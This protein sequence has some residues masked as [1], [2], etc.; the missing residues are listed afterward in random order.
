MILNRI[1]RFACLLIVCA[2]FNWTAAAAAEG[3]TPLAL[4]FEEMLDGEWAAALR[5]ANRAGPVARDIIEWHRLRAGRGSFDEVLDFLERRPDWPG[6]PH[7]RRRSE[8]A[9]P[10]GRRA[11]DV[12]A[13]FTPSAPR[14]G[15]GMVRLAA[16]HTELGEDDAAAATAIQAWRDFSMSKAQE[17]WL[18]KH[19]GERLRPHHE[20][21]LDMLIWTGR[22][23]AAEE[24]LPRVSKGWQALARARIAL[25]NTAPGVDTLIEKVP[26]ALANDPGLA[27]ERFLWRDRKDRDASAIELAISRP[28]TVE[29]L[30]RPAVWANKRR[31]FARAMMRQG[32]PATAYKLAAQHGLSEGSD[33]A[34]L[35]W[36][37]G[38]LS[39]RYLDNPE[40]A[41]THFLA[42][43]S[44]VVTPISLGRAGYWEGRALEDLGRE[45]EALAAYQRGGR[46]QTSFYGQLAAEKAGLKMDP[47]L[48]GQGSVPDW[49]DADFV[50]SSVFEAAVLLHKAGFRDLTER[51]LTHLT[52]SLDQ[53]QATQLANYAFSINEPHF[54]LMIAKRAAS[55]GIVLPEAYFPVVDLGLD[56]LPVPRELAL[57]I[58]R[59]ES[60]F[61]P[62]VRSHAGAVGLMQVMPATAQEVAGWLDITY[63][64]S[65][66]LNDPVYNAQ[67]GVTYL[68]E[69]TSILGENHM[70][71][72]A[73]YNAGPG[74]PI[75]WID[76]FG[77]PRTADID[78]VD[79][80][81]HIPFRE[82]RNYVMRVMES[83]PV[84]RARL[85]GEPQPLRLSKELTSG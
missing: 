48:A 73:G 71:V 41:L 2:Q 33:F 20:A 58:A 34:D 36:L 3:P 16:A 7:L 57:S 52:E 28:G 55:A 29:A 5:A 77:D 65:R 24:M 64:R 47:A 49:G 85:S 44:A 51:F 4:G 72:A 45:T 61:D 53:T 76:Q 35:E 10:L 74:R 13:F 79:W 56:A 9:V 66:L 26:A 46:Y 22:L 84:Y 83:L 31:A 63:S 68:A 23:G 67:L 8:G 38:Y 30:G 27:Y 1:L 59:R 25:R 50:N 12:V 69:L 17:A 11:R 32:K 42:F 15:A 70:L 80:I 39:L 21:R 75:R 19:F 14:T 60:E 18:L 82:T 40:A 43:R 62:G 78:P 6:L 54:A 81:E 37:A